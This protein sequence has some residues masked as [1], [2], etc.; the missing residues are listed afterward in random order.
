VS[1]DDRPDARTRGVAGAARAVWQWWTRVAR[2]IG[3]VQARVLL[4]AFYFAIL[5]PFALILRRGDPL[6]IRPGAPRGWRPRETAPRP[7]AEQ[8]RRQS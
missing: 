6:A 2:R 1:A 5:G 3:D 8:A 7:V 4:S